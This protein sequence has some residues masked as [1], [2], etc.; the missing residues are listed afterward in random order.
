MATKGRLKL[1]TPAQRGRLLEL[2][3]Y[4]HSV[5]GAYKALAREDDKLHEYPYNTVKAYIKSDQGRE[6][7]LDV[8]A[9]V[10]DELHERGFGGTQHRLSGLVEVAMDLLRTFRMT[11]DQ[12]DVDSMTKVAREFRATI[13]AIR[14][15]VG[16]AA[17]VGTT[18]VSFFDALKAEADGLK[19]AEHKALFG[20]AEPS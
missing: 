19:P 12:A 18:I 11:V 14:E 16:D 15:E 10:K 9:G 4:N 20:E 17:P 7:Y 1:W 6:D 8:L 2:M 3:S 13:Q 5:M